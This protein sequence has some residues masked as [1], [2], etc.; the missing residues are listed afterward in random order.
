MTSEQYARVQFARHMTGWLC[1]GSNA[2]G[3]ELPMIEKLHE[4]MRR[5]GTDGA[6]L[7]IGPWW[8]VFPFYA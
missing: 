2:W 8:P 6:A 4:A 3:D 1:D 7:P 5:G